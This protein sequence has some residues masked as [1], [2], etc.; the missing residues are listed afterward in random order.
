MNPE[1]L[2][3]C[4]SIDY[5][6][7]AIV[8]KELLKQPHTRLQNPCRRFDG[9]LKLTLC[10]ARMAVLARRTKASRTQTTGLAR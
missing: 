10:Q 5:Q 9:K 4:Q 2:N 7:G 8:S 6:E 1:K 3:L